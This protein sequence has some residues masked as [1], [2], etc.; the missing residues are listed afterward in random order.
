[1]LNHNFI[2]YETKQLIALRGDLKATLKNPACASLKEPVNNTI[3]QINAE[4]EK[5]G[6]HSILKTEV[7][8]LM[9]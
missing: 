1:M 3:A 8:K 4:L 6:L 7:I 5:R 2:P 9:A